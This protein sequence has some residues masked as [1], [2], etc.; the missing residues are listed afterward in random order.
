MSSTL[1]LF[2]TLVFVAWLFRHDFL[3]KPNV[4]G[5]LWIPYLWLFIGGTKAVTEWLDI[6]GLHWGGTSADEGSPVDALFTFGL[7]GAGLYVV[8]Q[9]RVSLVEFMRN[10]QW[11]TIYLAY[12]FLAILWS[13]MPLVAFK[14]WI[15]LF[16][17]PVMVL[18][19]LTEPD[20]K[21]ALIRLLKRCAY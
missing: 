16:G 6:F 19:V 5:A 10:N 1:A 8:H 11:V 20:P 7:I 2:V 15:K 9:R 13:D 21:E 12:C 14:R 17:Q 4:T 3:Q 18:V